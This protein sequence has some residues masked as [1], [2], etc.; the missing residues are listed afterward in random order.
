VVVKELFAKLGLEIDEVAFE[1]GEAAIHGLHKGLLTFAGLAVAGAAVAGAAFAKSFADSASAA[2]K[3]AQR[4]GLPLKESQELAFA[5]EASGASVESLQVALGHLASTGVK[6]VG[7]EIF[8][9]A[10]QFQKMPDGAE[11]IAL[12]R[13]AFGRGGQE[14][15]PFLNKGT[16]GIH[17]LMEEADEL[18]VILTEKDV[19]AAKAFK[20]ELHAFEAASTATGYAIGRVLLPFATKLIVW[21]NRFSHALKA[22]PKFLRDNIQWVKGIAIVLG[23]VLLTA[24]GANITA[25][26]SLVAGY[27]AAGVAAV[28]AAAKA[29]G[30]WLAAVAPF[31]LIAAA[32]AFVLLVLEDLYQFLTGGESVIG[33]FVEYVKSEFSGWKGFFSALFQWLK[34]ILGWNWLVEATK[35]AWAKIKNIVLKEAME[36]ASMIPG[37]SLALSAAAGGSLFGGGASPSASVGASVNTAS[38]GGVQLLAPQ[39]GGA[40]FVI[41]AGAGGDA[42]D[43]ADKVSQAHDEW[44]N[45]KLRPV[46]EG[47]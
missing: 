31:A 21:L 3:F 23:S 22:L 15:I 5:A 6:D 38:T 14:L 46:L 13:K 24:I 10:A 47:D 42:K 11:K 2:S 19:K 45:A 37:V 25:I 16:E 8:R 17:Q 20:K 44:W 7:K 43:I 40:N 4:I 39:V 41:N 26:W 30:S 35:Y 34:E 28:V 33:D 12:A 1:K 27:V 29:V 9:L 18:G 36:L 32:I